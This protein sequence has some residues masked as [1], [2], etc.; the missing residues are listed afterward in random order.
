MGRGHEQSDDAGVELKTETT[1]LLKLPTFSLMSKLQLLR[2]PLFTSPSPPWDARASVPFHWEEVP[3]KPKSFHARSHEPCR[4]ARSKLPPPPRLSGA[5]MG[6]AGFA[7]SPP[8]VLHRTYTDH[9]FPF[10]SSFSSECQCSCGSSEVAGTG[11]A[12]FCSH[13]GSSELSGK[14]RIP[15]T[16]R[17]WRLPPIL[18]GRSHSWVSSSNVQLHF[19]LLRT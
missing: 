5:H 13:G 6:N 11:D 17:T 3:G 16:T 2:H 10:S 18:Q 9:S 4:C 7:H 15:R 14:A 12:D 8:A 1:E 19:I